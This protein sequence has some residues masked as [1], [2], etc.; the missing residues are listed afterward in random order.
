M[1]GDAELNQ[2]AIKGLKEYSSLDET[3]PPLTANVRQ[4]SG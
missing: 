1:A 2:I 4:L 3:D